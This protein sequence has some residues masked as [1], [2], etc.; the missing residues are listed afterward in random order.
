MWLSPAFRSWNIEDRTSAR[1][2]CP[3]LVVQGDADAYG[4]TAQL[5]AIE[6][7][8][9]GPVE[10]LLV[11]GAGHAPQLDAPAVVTE[12]VAEFVSGLDAG[13]DGLAANA[14]YDQGKRR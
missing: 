14:S 13:A 6:A 8:V 3:V 1:S 2:T 12:R 4:T 5:D 10:R 11:C 9:A 7:G